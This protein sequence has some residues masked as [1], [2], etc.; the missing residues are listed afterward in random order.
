MRN[1]LNFL[2]TLLV[3]WIG[4]EYFHQY[5]AIKDTKTLIIASVLMFVIS[6]LFSLAMVLSV[7]LITVGIGCLTTPAL[8]LVS[9]I[10]TPIK[11]WLL[12]KYLY[13]FE[14]HGFWTYVI[15]TLVLSLFTVKVKHKKD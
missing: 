6:L 5:V 9:L 4:N 8:M 11:L 3:F 12:D 15:L 13:G 1:L 7:L 2:V 10:L 14:I